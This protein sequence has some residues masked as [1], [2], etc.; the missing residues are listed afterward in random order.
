[1]T[2]DDCKKLIAEKLTIIGGA[3]ADELV[4]WRGF[5]TVEGFSEVFHPDLLK[6]MVTEGLIM[7]VKYTL[8]NAK[9]SSS[10]L[11]PKGTKVSIIGL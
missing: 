11:V 4:A 5:Y 10:F 3:R 9:N 7:E 6:Q 1:M 2:K 8:P